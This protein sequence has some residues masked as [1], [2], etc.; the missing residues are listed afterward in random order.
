MAALLALAAATAAG[1]AAWA[2]PLAPNVVA[3]PGAL[4]AADREAIKAF[5][6]RHAPGLSA[7]E[8]AK[9]Q[10]SR[11][12]LIAPLQEASASVSFRSAYAAEL[13]P[14]LQPL[15]G[16]DR[17]VVAVNAMRLAGKMAHTQAGP[18]IDAGLKST[19]I[20]VR[21]AAVAAIGDTFDTLARSAPAMDI[22]AARDLL[23]KLGPVLR[24]EAE[25]HIFDAAVRALMSAAAIDREGWGHL[26][27]DAMNQL[28]PA[29]SERLQKLGNQ[30]AADAFM[31]AI[32]RANS[33]ARDTLLA[34]GG[35]ALGPEAAKN[36]AALGGDSLAY[37]QRMVQAGAFPVIQND[38]GEA[39]QEQKTLARVVPADL[40]SVSFA[41]VTFA[42]DAL[43]GP[44]MPAPLQQLPQLLRSARPQD[45]AQFL[46]SVRD[47][48]GPNGVLA[49]PPFSFAKDR[50]VK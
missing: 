27:D 38:D 32:I 42:S 29:V 50:F 31:Q 14:A 12:E 13:A 17:D 5:V 33:A 1:P 41:T 45:D 46:V 21:Y 30:P 20:S 3:A 19:K 36:V 15:A 44:A 10:Q 34:G 49:K 37:V 47:V 18:I 25:A 4:S 22:G 24:T 39:Q 7:A 6:A 35:R 26:R 43:S 16:N 40:A 11:A 2:Q 48:I 9:V 23:R 28:A 8:N